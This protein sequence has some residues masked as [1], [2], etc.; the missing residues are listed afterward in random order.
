[1]KLNRLLPLALAVIALASC[2]KE[3]D[4]IEVAQKESTCKPVKVYAFGNNASILDSAVYEYTGD[5]LTKAVLSEGDYIAYEYNGANVSRRSIFETGSAQPFAYQVLSYG[6]DGNLSKLETYLNV[7]FGFGKIDS[8][9]LDYSNGK[10]ASIR[11]FAPAV[12]PPHPMALQ[13]ELFFTYTGNNIT[14]VTEKQ[15]ADGTPGDEESYLL[16]Y[17]NQPNYFRK[18]SA[19][20]LQTDPIFISAEYYFYVHA[21]SENNVVR[22][23]DESSPSDTES[24]SYTTDAKGNLEEMK[25]DGEAILRYFYECK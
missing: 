16:T 10:L 25:V 23:Q 2:Q 7:G 17:D 6:T 15:Y 1:M 21:L 11:S 5:K 20:F 14:T 24:Y 3:P 8:A 13:E 4:F 9:N 12:T 18:Q 19:Q 22:A